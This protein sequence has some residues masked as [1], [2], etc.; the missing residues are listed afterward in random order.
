MKKSPQSVLEIPNYT[1]VEVVRYFHLSFQRLEYWTSGG[2]NHALVRLAP[3]RRPQI[4][5]KN[6]VEFYVLEGLRD[7]HGLGMS[8]IRRALS[9]MLNNSNSL[10]PFAD[11]EI[12]T[13]DKDV[14]FFENGHPVNASRYGQ[15]AL[16]SIVG[17][18]LIR[19]SRNPRGLAESIFPLTRKEYV[20]EV[21]DKAVPQNVVEI[22]P[23]KCFGIPVLFNS[24]ITTPFLAGRYRGGES[25]PAIAKSY[26][27]PVGTI[28]EAIEWEIGQE[29]QAA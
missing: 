27:R 22:H 12:R 26:G 16:D 15:I 9:Y 5:F 11:Y 10:H 18:Y 14:W 6:M 3:G 19:V 2:R 17:P 29:L 21:R 1:P 28:K 7:V 13:D 24:R 8:N 25:V 20:K 23:L 4:S